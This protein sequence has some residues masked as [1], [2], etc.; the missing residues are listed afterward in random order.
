[1]LSTNEFIIDE[2][3]FSSCQSLVSI[4]IDGAEKIN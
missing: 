3:A 2:E 4:K 1:M